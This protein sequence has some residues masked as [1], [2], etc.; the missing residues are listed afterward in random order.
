MDHARERTRLRV[1][2]TRALG[3]ERD[4][5]RVGG[6][7]KEL[8]GALRAQ[9]DELK[10]LGEY[11]KQ[12]A[13]V[14]GLLKVKQSQATKD[15]Y[16][17]VERLARDLEQKQ[18]EIAGAQA[19][20]RRAWQAH[21]ARVHTRKLRQMHAAREVEQ[22][23][24]QRTRPRERNFNRPCSRERGDGDEGGVRKSREAWVESDER[25]GVDGGVGGAGR[26]GGG[27]GMQ[28]LRALSGASDS[29]RDLSRDED[30][31]RS[32]P[33][34]WRVDADALA[35]TGSAVSA[36]GRRGQAAEEWV[37]WSGRGKTEAQAI[38]EATANARREV[39]ASFKSFLSRRLSNIAANTSFS[40][41]TASISQPSAAGAPPAAGQ[42]DLTTA[43]PPNSRMDKIGSIG[44]SGKGSAPG[45]VGADAFGSE[46]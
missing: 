37:G 32:P 10:A 25:G 16:W 12:K 44:K 24:R 22:R 35:N 11:D 13:K 30:D 21:Q 2:M 19:L 45:A 15:A 41:V 7:T 17:E 1:E 40:P 18:S 9:K 31:R 42:G 3:G 6:W 28:L 23:L 33:P 29:S 36:G 34:P 43:R 39:E 46:L 5:Q 27:V 20:L 4:R 8:E 26:R 38:A 14:L